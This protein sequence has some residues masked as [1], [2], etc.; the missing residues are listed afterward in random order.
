MSI[1]LF[2][3]FFLTI[4]IFYWFVSICMRPCLWLFLLSV[5]FCLSM[6]FWAVAQIGDKVLWKRSSVHQSILP[7][8]CPL[9]PEGPRARQVSLSQQAGLRA[10][11]P[12]RPHSQPARPQSKPARPQSKP[13]RPQSQVARIACY[14]HYLADSEAYLADSWTLWGRGQTNGWTDWQT[15]NLIYRTLHP[16][17]A[18]DQITWTDKTKTDKQRDRHQKGLIK[19][20]VNEKKY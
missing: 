9:P 6:F 11:Q 10:S 7:S 15:E 1:S 13:V 17:W 16:I 4:S 18:A 2:L 5:S 19:D 14:E 12:A 20:G 3:V 8:V